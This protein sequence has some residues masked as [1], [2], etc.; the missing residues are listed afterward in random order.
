MLIK[1]LQRA[2]SIIKFEG[3]TYLEIENDKDSIYQ[4]GIVIFL[5]ALVNVLLFKIYI[6]PTLP[7]KV[8][9]LLV[10]ILWVFFNWFIFSIILS[11]IAKQN[12]SEISHKDKRTALCL[13]GFSNSAE[14]LKILIIF[15]PNFIVFFSWGILMLV[16]ASQA[17]GVKQIY[18]LEKISTAIG[19]VILSY[20]ILTLLIV[21]SVILLIKL[22]Y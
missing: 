20:I 8:P 7:S 5:A 3:N 10:L 13:V 17:L 22:A 15:F 11:F 9:I 2:L 12:S 1:T 14:I 19:C 16:I 18:K 6:L 4:S 21:I